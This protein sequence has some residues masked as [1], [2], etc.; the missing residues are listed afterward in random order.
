MI[1]CYLV[2]CGMENCLNFMARIGI[3][4]SSSSSIEQVYY[5]I[6]SGEEFM[7][8]DPQRDAFCSEQA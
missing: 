3:N 7:K 2:N 5:R 1:G 4:L 6:Q 8:Q